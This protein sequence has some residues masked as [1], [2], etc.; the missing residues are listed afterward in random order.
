MHYSTITTPLVAAM[1]FSAGA[2]AGFAAAAARAGSAAARAG[3]AAAGA[4]R[5]VGSAPGRMGG[6]ISKTIKGLPD[7]VKSGM[8]SGSVS[9]TISGSVG[10]GV[11]VGIG[12]NGGQ[13]RAKAR[14]AV[15]SQK[16][17]Q[18]ELMGRQELPEGFGPGEAPEGLSQADWDRCYYDGLDAQ[19]VVTG[20]IDNG[21]NIQIDGIPASC[22]PLNTVLDGNPAGGAVPEPC[23]S[24]CLKYKGMT[25]EDYNAFK[26]IFEDLRTA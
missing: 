3:Q 7:P 22:M 17:Y 25:E 13:S 6:A 2:D 1:A 9:G 12:K 20:P 8:T 18:R 11:G 24:A 16:M 23:G 21:N 4:A 15:Q 19:I 26:E 5:A 10:I 14:R